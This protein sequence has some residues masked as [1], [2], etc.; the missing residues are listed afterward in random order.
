MLLMQ[1][2]PYIRP[3]D[4][5]GIVSTASKI[6][7]EI[8]LP[9]VDLLKSIGYEVEIGKHVF[10]IHNQFAGTDKQRTAD[11]QAM[12]DDD[13]IK[14]I[15][16]SRGGYGTLRTIQNISWKKFK[17]SAKWIVGFSDITV[18]HSLL[19]QIGICSIHGV[20]PKNFIDNNTTTQ[21]FSTLLN[22]L[23][24]KTNYYSVK[25]SGYNR[26]GKTSGQLI[27]GNL[28]ILYSLRGTPYDIDTNRKILFIEGISEYLYHIDRIIMNLKTGGKLS[29]LAGLIVGSFT[30]M[31]DSD[32]P[33]GKTVEEIIASAVDEYNFPVAFN[34]PA[35][36]QPD[37][38]ALKIGDVVKIE[39]TETMATIIQ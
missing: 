11:L 13:S 33:F 27:G 38:Y 23:T 1:I 37:N 25:P 20:M 6:D 3:G 17:K 21:S 32:T 5:I 2:P 14:A 31:K 12:L 26:K 19:N 30:G 34:F 39:V 28:S 8:I 29:G 24:G 36:H 9:A 16:C 18:L 22:A 7:K 4:K 10:A 15:I 35:G